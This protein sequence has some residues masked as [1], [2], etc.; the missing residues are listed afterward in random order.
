VLRTFLRWFVVTIVC[1]IGVPLVAGVTILGSLIFL[2]LPATL[3]TPKPGIVSLPSTVYDAAGNVIATFQQFDQNIPVAEK[4]I[5]QILKDALVASEDKNFFHEGGVDPRG[6]LRAF[7]R[8]LQGQ[9]YLQG[10]STITQQYVALAYTGKQRTFTRKLREAI[11]ASQL[12]RKL[13]KDEILYKYLSAVYFGDGLYGVGAAAQGYFRLQNLQQMTIG[14]AALLVGLIPAPSRYEPRGNEVIAEERRETVLLKM[15]QQHY[16]NLQ[17]YQYWKVAQIYP[18]NA[19]A[20]PAGSPETLVYPPEQQQT[21]YPYFVDYLRRYLEEYPG[22]GPDL[23]YRGGLRIQTTLDPKLEQEAEASVAKT[24]DGTS[25]PLEMALVSIEPQTGHVRALVGGRDFSQ[26]QTNL[27]LG[28][29]QQP[30]PGAQVL[31]AA[32]CQTSEVPQGGGTGRQPGS[33]FKPFVLATAFA[34]GVLPSTVFNGPQSIALPVGCKGQACQVIHNAGDSESGVFTLQQATWFSV[35]TVYAQL[36]LDPRV[37]V[38]QTAE[39]AK[40]LGI[41]S[42]WY[43]PQVHGASYALGALDVSPLDMASAYGVFDNHGVRVPS[44]PVLLVENPNGKILIDNRAPTGTRVLGSAVA[45]NVTNVLKGVITQPGATAY[46]TANIGRPAAGKTGTTSS[47]VDAWFVGYT[48]TLVTSVW[49]GKKNTEDPAKGASMYSVCS[50]GRHTC[51]SPVFG[52]TLPAM[53]WADYMKQAMQGVPPTDFNQPAPLSPVADA[54]DTL[55]RH[56]ISPGARRYPAVVGGGGPY[57][58]G[59]PPPV[60][61]PPT[62]TTIPTT[63]T[64]TPGASSTTSTTARAP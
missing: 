47:Y 30:P 23:L 46:G 38:Q 54:I 1:A 20:L 17:Q 18:A 42:A 49:M 44:T 34:H 15:F 56:G 51:A 32:T 33:S 45:D 21:Q 36:I 31:V 29:C 25:P 43:S 52:G 41:T 4:D 7:V 53:T 11:L 6:T 3:P 50:A 16:I 59:P 24:L 37:T 27:A 62:T 9:G 12:A 26:D 57:V 63:S 14:E 10:G 13:P 8:D 64:T 61:Q 58:E 28:G 48:P 60:A 19:P 40:A 39:T 55:L 2:P 35:N 5:P 22:I